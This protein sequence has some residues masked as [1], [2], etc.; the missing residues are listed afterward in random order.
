[1]ATLGISGIVSTFFH[2]L[3]LITRRLNLLTGDIYDRYICPLQTCSSSSF[4]FIHRVPK[5]PTYQNLKVPI[6]PL[7]LVLQVWHVKPTYRNSWAKNL[8]MCSDLTLGTPSRPKRTA[9][10]F[11]TCLLLVLKVWDVKQ[12]YRKSYATMWSDLTSGPL[13]KVK[14]VYKN[15]KVPVSPVLLLLG[16]RNVKPNNRKSWSRNHLM[17]SDLTFGSSF[18]VK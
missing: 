18:K 11:I 14:R 15:L 12:T 10:V 13:F 5:Y 9:K 6:S 16:V 4:M 2:W 1:M 8:L 3:V 17:C 7:L